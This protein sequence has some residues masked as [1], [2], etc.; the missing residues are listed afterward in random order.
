VAVCAR[1][2]AP[3]GDGDK[4]ALPVPCVAGKHFL[5]DIRGHAGLSI[6]ES[7]EKL[8]LE[9]ERAALRIR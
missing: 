4:M 2:A 9:E 3:H 5:P 1:R 6:V 8:G 7:L